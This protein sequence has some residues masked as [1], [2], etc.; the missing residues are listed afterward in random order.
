MPSGVINAN[1]P[2]SRCRAAREQPAAAIKVT[3]VMASNGL[4]RMM[5]R[6]VPN[7]TNTPPCTCVSDTTAA[8]SATP[9]VNECKDSP[10]AVASQE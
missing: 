6:A 8:A 5:A 10:I 1:S 4:C 3:I 7:P 9:P 2:F